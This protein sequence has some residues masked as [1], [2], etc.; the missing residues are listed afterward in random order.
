MLDLHNEASEPG[1]FPSGKGS[2]VEGV[3]RHLGP[4]AVKGAEDSDH[5]KQTEF[6]WW[7]PGNRL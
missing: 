1:N 7:S 3:K 5:H 2:S 6:S 4:P